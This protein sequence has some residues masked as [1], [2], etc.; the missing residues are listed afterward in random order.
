MNQLVRQLQSERREEDQ[1]SHGNNNYDTTATLIEDQNNQVRPLVRR[2]I[3][4]A[5][6]YDSRAN[7]NDRIELTNRRLQ[8]DFNSI[9][10][11]YPQ[12]IFASRIPTYDDNFLARSESQIQ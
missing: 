7:N 6:G 10:P 5:A 3:T 9:R 1:E 4:R 11:R 8:R 2:P 12:S